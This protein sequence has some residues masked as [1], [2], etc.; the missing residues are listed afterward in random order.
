MGKRPDTRDTVEDTT[1]SVLRGGRNRDRT[2][3]DRD[4][5]DT[6]DRVD[7]GRRPNMHRTNT[8]HTSAPLLRDSLESKYSLSRLLVLLLSSPDLPFYLDVARGEKYQG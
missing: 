6:E 8:G 1:G 4:L 5:V 2:A 3:A 7:T